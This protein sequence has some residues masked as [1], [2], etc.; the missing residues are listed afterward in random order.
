MQGLKILILEDEILVARDLMNLLQD[1]GYVILDCCKTGAEG[2]EVFGQSEPDII[3]AD[4][5]LKGDL[6]GIDAVRKMTEIKQVPVIFITAQADF[7]TITRAKATMPSAYL[8]KPFNEQNLMISIDLALHNFY[9][10]LPPTTNEKENAPSA[11]EV[12]LGAD[13]ILKSNNHLFIK[14]NYRFQKYSI[15][16]L[17]YLEADKNY[18]MMYFKQH[19]IAIRLPLQAVYDRL[20]EFETIV[21]VHRSFVINILHIE[22]FT[23]SEII[24]SKNKFIPITAIYKEAFLEKFKVL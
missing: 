20:I 3:L 18:T 16:D 4:I 9:H 7:Q 11:N 8:L 5:Q 1:W 12:K 15:D 14:Q 17:M 21:R 10:H 24:L 19:K 2:I 22:E 6:D 23:E 13:V